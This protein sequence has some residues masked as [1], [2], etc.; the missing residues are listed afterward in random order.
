LPKISPFGTTPF[1]RIGLVR[2]RAPGARA[3]G[4]ALL[5]GIV[6]CAL[7]GCVSAERRMANDKEQCQAQGYA[8]S[9]AE[10][11]NCLSAA[12][13]RHDEAEARQ[14]LRMR[15]AHEQEVDNFLTSTSIIP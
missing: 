12:A 6:A 7:V 2:E 10:F 9:S 8:P 1:S 4:R 5:L 13:A 3:G 15:Q 11:S 14:S